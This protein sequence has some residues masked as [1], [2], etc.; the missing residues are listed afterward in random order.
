MK[1]KI[2]L[3]KGGSEISYLHTDK[4]DLSKQGRKIVT[5][6][7]DVEFCHDSQEWIAKLNNGKEIARSFSRDKVLQTE[8][9]VIE[10]ML[11][12]GI[13]IP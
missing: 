5:R 11:I 9:E 13:C 8:R 3:N 1:I 10:Q 2:I 4:I 6:A 12:D 7:S